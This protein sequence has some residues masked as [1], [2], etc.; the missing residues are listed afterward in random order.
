[1]T[2]SAR[3]M[4][5]WLVVV[6]VIAMV[7]VPTAAMFEPRP[8]RFGWQMFTAMAPVPAAWVETTDGNERPVDVGALLV[9]P[10]PEADLAPAL[11]ELLCRQAEVRAV[12]VEG[13]RSRSRISC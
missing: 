4:R 8:A 9:H 10:R 13:L 3:M 12:V 7:A 5:R 2:S 6:S 1:M 11:A